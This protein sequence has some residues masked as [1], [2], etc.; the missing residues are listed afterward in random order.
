MTL[1]VE[2]VS[3]TLV[4]LQLLVGDMEPTGDPSVHLQEETRIALEACP[5]AQSPTAGPAGRG[6]NGA[7][8]KQRTRGCGESRASLGGERASALPCIILRL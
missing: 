6:D 3:R 1:S 4:F 5:G 7:D 2:E 8:I